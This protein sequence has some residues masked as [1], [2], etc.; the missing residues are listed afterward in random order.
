VII[1]FTTDVLLGTGVGVVVGAFLPSV[2]RKIKSFFVKETQAARLK[3]LTEVTKVR[4]DIKT[5]L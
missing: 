5:Q 2:G 3:V 4:Q 1:K